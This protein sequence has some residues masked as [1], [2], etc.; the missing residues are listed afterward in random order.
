MEHLKLQAILWVVTSLDLLDKL[1]N[2]DEDSVVAFVKLC[3][4]EDGGYGPAPNFSSSLLCT[5]SALQ[6]KSCVLCLLC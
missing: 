5:L 1:Q 6:V 3:Q 4:N 2:I